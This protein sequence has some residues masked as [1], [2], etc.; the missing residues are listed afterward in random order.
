MEFQHTFCELRVLDDATSFHGQGAGE[1]GLDVD[2]AAIDTTQ[3]RADDCLLVVWTAQEVVQDVRH[4]GGVNV[5]RQVLDVDA[6]VEVGQ[7][8]LLA[9]G[10]DLLS[11]RVSWI[12]LYHV[13]LGVLSRGLD[14]R[15][16][17]LS[18]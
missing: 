14:D 16:L 18:V 12:C 4:D 15:K 5:A 11:D 13:R 7:V 17:I 6:V 8:G 2:F 9:R 3:E 10:L 1:T